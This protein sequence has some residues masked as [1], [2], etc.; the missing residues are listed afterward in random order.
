ML[1]LTSLTH[2]QALCWKHSNI[3]YFH[4]NK[5]SHTKK[6]YEKFLKLKISVINVNP[7]CENKTKSKVSRE[8]LKGQKFGS[9]NTWT[10]ANHGPALCKKCL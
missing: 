4:S 7:V 3:I 5:Y 1:I 10:R 8:K 2:S 9:L 6:T